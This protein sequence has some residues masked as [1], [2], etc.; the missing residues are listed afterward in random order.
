MNRSY[1]CTRKQSRDRQTL[2][3]N[4]SDSITDFTKQLTDECLLSIFKYLKKDDICRASV[5]SKKWNRISKDRNLWRQVD[6]NPFAL[7]LGEQSFVRLVKSKLKR[8]NFL[9][10]GGI[11]VTFRMLR[12]IANNCRYLKFLT[13]S[14]NCTVEEIT[15]KQQTVAFPKSLET[16]DIRSVTGSFGFLNFSGTSF[17]KLVNL[18]VGPKTFDRMQLSMLFWK[19]PCLRIAD[20]TNCLEVDD[21]SIKVLG[22]ECVNL[23]SL[24]LIGCR[25]VYGSTF[26]HLLSLCSHLKTLLLRYLKI[27]DHILATSIW[28]NSKIEELDISACPRITWQGLFPFLVQLKHLQYLNMSYCGDGMA[29]NDTVL[30]EMANQGIASQLTMLDIRWSFHITAEALSNFLQ[31]CACLQ[32]LGIYQSFKITAKHISCLVNQLPKIKIF[33]FG[34]SIPQDLHTSKLIPEITASNKN[35]EVLSIINF[36]S[37][38]LKDDFKDIKMLVK[39]SPFLKRINFCDCSPGLVEIGKEAVRNN[40]RVEATVKWECALPPPRITLDALI[41]NVLR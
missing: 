6:L 41:Q 30:Y 10:M 17:K 36:T 32:N 1:I 20:F 19:L 38:C 33:E 26:G 9:N 40:H 27:E 13:F 34:A 2:M 35:I 23:E 22:Q 25:N 5:V 12:C 24:C 39:G 11:Q 15:K 8:T 21:L 7:R 18:G 31:K 16:L 37:A 4:D 14:R 29:V 3:V 28:R